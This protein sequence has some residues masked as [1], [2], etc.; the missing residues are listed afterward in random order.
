MLRFVV[1]VLV[2]ANIGY[3]GW[4]QEWFASL[5]LAPV[6]QSEPQRVE[7]QVNRD[8]LRIV[9]SNEARRLQTQAASTPNQANTC[10]QSAMLDE[11]QVAAVRQAI[12]GWPAEVWRIDTQAEP[13][14]WIVYMGRYADADAVNRKKAELRQRNV[15]FEA[16]SPSLEPGLLLGSFDNEGDANARLSALSQKGVRTAKVVQERAAVKG[17]SLHIDPID[18]AL[19]ARIDEVRPAL[20]GKSLRACR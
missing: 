2:A 3:Y 20:G 8:A 11:N 12:A 9:S 15:V 7:Q 18:D 19:R 1:I 5:G 10:L 16:P 13:A 14:K 17:F 4:T 6:E